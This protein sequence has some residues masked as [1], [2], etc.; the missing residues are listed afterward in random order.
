MGR[1]LM[2]FKNGEVVVHKSLGSQP[3]V[4]V[5]TLTCEEHP[6]EGI[7][8]VVVSYGTQSQDGVVFREECFSP[9][10]LETPV[11]SIEREGE[12]FKTL[13]TKRKQ[14]QDESDDSN[15]ESGST[16]INIKHLN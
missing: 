5:D 2:S 1:M 15:S 3:L 12:I 7:T 4:V 14:I 6:D 9:D 8:G 16:P 13:N 10:E 11:E